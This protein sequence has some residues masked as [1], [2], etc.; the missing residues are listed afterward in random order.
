MKFVTTLDELYAKFVGL[1]R[2]F[3]DL[4]YDCALSLNIGGSI[5]EISELGRKRELLSI[6]FFDM[7]VKA[8]NDEES[9]LNIYVLW[10]EPFW[11]IRTEMWVEA[12]IGGMNR[13][14][15]FP[16]R[17]VKTFEEFIIQLDASID[18][19]FANRHLLI[20]W[21]KSKESADKQST[22]CNRGSFRSSRLI[23]S[24]VKL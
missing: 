4:G 24:G 22:S 16:E 12:D 10:D 1:G 14:K 19:L 9:S 18:D 5:F 8:G 17:Q 2:L 15:S 20:E 23:P 11:I 13:L 6:I 21:L 7:G 3:S